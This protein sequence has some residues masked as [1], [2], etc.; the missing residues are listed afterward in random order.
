MLTI[1]KIKFIK[2]SL[3]FKWNLSNSE[4]SLILK[5]LL[6]FRS[7]YNLLIVLIFRPKSVPN[8]PSIPRA[9]SNL[10][11]Q[12]SSAWSGNSKKKHQSGSSSQVL[13]SEDKKKWQSSQDYG[14]EFT[15]IIPCAL[16]SR[17]FQNAK[18]RLAQLSEVLLMTRK[19]LLWCHIWMN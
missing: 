11:H 6:R 10:R 19:N 9:F 13:S 7:L 3:L 18:L 16:C 12:L 2:F 4:F 15:F 8:S 14:G 1:F 5:G 17:N